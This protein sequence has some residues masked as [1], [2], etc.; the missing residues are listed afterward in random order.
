MSKRYQVF[1]SS[2]YADLKE[3]RSKI[4]Q[5]I[6]E[7]DCIPAGMEIFPAIDEEQFNFIKSIIDDCDYYLLII[8]GRYGSVSE[9]G[10]S[11]TEKE[12]NYAVEKGIK[13][14]AFVHSNPELIPL[15]K[16]EIDPSLR[17]K[18]A[19]FRSKVSSN[20]L[21]RFWTNA[22]ELQGLV[23]SSLSKTIKTYPAVGWIRANSIANP[24]LLHELNE[25][26][27][28]NI[29]L[30]SKINSLLTNG[31]KIEN[32]AGFEDKFVVLGMYKF[33]NSA[34]TYFS[35]EASLT[36][37]DI[38]GLISPYFLEYKYEVDIRDKMSNIIFKKSSS[39]QQGESPTIVDEIFQKIKIHF[40]ALE[41]ITVEKNV[42]VQWHLT[43]YGSKAMLEIGS[44]KKEVRI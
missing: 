13:V 38:F 32:I 2:T 12:Y 35:W 8:G 36:W 23:M 4:I 26:R 30:N 6:M 15:G 5:A 37:G 22:G 24:E 44:A 20:R 11:Y 27:K 16:S 43:K 18:L 42:M 19:E 14:I 39:F 40:M 9:D 41:L 28:E 25:Q 3:E 1:V 10:F 17:E 31:D 34:S 29:E 7:L 33:R 21:I